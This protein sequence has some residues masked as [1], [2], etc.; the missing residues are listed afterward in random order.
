M[1]HELWGTETAADCF[2]YGMRF[3]GH[4]WLH[5]NQSLR[6]MGSICG[7]DATS[8][9]CAEST[10]PQLINLNLRDESNSASFAVELRKVRHV[11]RLL[12]VPNAIKGASHVEDL[13]PEGSLF[14]T[15]SHKPTVEYV[16]PKTIDSNSVACINIR[17]SNLS[18]ANWGEKTLV[19]D[20][21][22]PVSPWRYDETLVSQ[23]C[24]N[25]ITSGQIRLMLGGNRQIRRFHFTPA[26][27]EEEYFTLGSA[28]V[29]LMQE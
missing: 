11:S 2:N 8:T 10:I 19:V 1:L 7:F 23:P 28:E 12:V 4:R 15:T 26:A 14:V 18:S 6:R 27:N 20:H 21:P 29:F 3:T 9:S 17:S 24:M 13:S 22:D 16:L 5:D 25:L